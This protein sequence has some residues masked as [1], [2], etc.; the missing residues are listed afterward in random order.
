LKA[1]VQYKGKLSQDYENVYDVRYMLKE[2]NMSVDII[3]ILISTQWEQFLELGKDMD[4]GVVEEKIKAQK[5]EQ[6]A[7]LIYTVSAKEFIKKYKFIIIYMLLNS[8]WHNR[9][10]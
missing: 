1:V 10:S 6:C 8:V 5:P 3:I 7:L 2:T 4:D 9:K